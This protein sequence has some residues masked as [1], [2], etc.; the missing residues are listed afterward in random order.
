MS[1]TTITFCVGLGKETYEKLG[2]YAEAKQRQAEQAGFPGKVSKAS[3]AQ[4]A[5]REYMRNHPAD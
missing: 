5:V 1:K 2:V 4:A 3:V